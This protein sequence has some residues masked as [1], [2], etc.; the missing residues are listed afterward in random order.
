[1]APCKYILLLYSVNDDVEITMYVTISRPFWCLHRVLIVFTSKE[2]ND[3]MK[4]TKNIMDVLQH[5]G[6]KH[7]H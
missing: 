5:R 3:G 6:T 7:R 1:M 2:L 4:D